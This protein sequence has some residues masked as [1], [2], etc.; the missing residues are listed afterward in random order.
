MPAAAPAAIAAM[1]QSTLLGVAI[2]K[3]PQELRVAETRQD[4]MVVKYEPARSYLV[5]TPVQWRLL[6]RFGEGRSAPDVLCELISQRRCPPLNEFY[7]LVVKAFHLGV[8]QVKGQALPAAEAPIEWRAKASD[9]PA[10]WLALIAMAGALVTVLLRPIVMP[11]HVGHLLFGWFLTCAAT[12]AGYALAACVVRG[13]GGE[14]YRPKFFWRTLAPH[15]RV[16]LDDVIMT[17]REIEITVALMRIAPQFVVTAVTALYWPSVL[18]PLLCGVFFHL[19]PFWRSPLQDLLRALYH[20]PKLSTTYDFLFVR[21]QLFPVLLRSKIKYANRKFLAV[22]SGVTLAWLLLVFLSGCALLQLNAIELLR[23][24]QAAGGLNFTALALLTTFGLMAL[25]ALGITLWIV[26]SHMITWS[27]DRLARL[28]APQIIPA[29]PQHIREALRQSQ[30]FRELADDD[31][32]TIAQAVKTQ[33]HTAKSYVLHEGEPGDHLYVILSGRVEVLR[34]LAVGRPEPVAELGPSEIFGEIALLEGG[35]RRRSVRCATRCVL[36]SLSRDQFQKLVL[37][38]LSR[39]Q[40]VDAVQKAAFLHRIPLSRQWSPQAT[41]S[42]ARRSTFQE[43]KPGEAVIHEGADNPFFY[44]IYEGEL[45]VLKQR[46]EVA[47]LTSGAFFGE[48]SLLQN[49]VATADIVSHTPSRCLAMSKHEFLQFVTGDFVIGLQFEQV[50][51]QRLGMP[52]FPL[53]GRGS[54][55][56]ARN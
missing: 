43:F 29:D 55:E 27:R 49:S 20:D 30:L 2:L 23:R 6:Q 42:F 38:H 3:L 41:N 37:T 51:S 46:H 7:E 31:L 14:L 4:R 18:F 34:E 13:G 54:F 33:E 16:D 9:R 32:E 8:L 39:H 52:L 28:R 22:C 17:G 53:K 45:S 36:L 15:F 1:D 12:S 56:A 10:R 5:L 26:G 44:L 47:R 24:F 50:G 48:I 25:S 19:S 11:A 35:P 40:I 21:N